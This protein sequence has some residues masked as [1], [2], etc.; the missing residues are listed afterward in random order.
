MTEEVRLKRIRREARSFIG[1]EFLRGDREV[2]E[3][4]LQA[5]LEP[6]SVELD[7]SPLR[8]KIDEI[9][10]GDEYAEYDSKIDAELAPTV[11]ETLDLSRREASDPGLWHY[12]TVLVFPDFVRY[13]W[14]FSSETAMREKFLGAGSDIY[15]NA[16][17]RLWWAAELTH[18]SGDYSR[19]KRVLQSQELSNDIFDRWFARYR[20]AVTAVADALQDEP[21][22]VISE[23]TTELRQRLS[24]F[25]LEA[26]TEDEIRDLVLEIKR[27]VE[28]GA[29]GDGTDEE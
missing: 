16:L 1:E 15:S 2:D 29:V 19:T 14:R 22:D 13:R 8:T 9:V 25:R 10:S 21:S 4:D 28:S 12:L 3:S 6:T 18:E 26:L 17:H 23:T 20:P 24:V 5:Y 27:E 11:H 7:I